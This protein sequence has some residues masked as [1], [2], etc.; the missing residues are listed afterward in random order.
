MLKENIQHS[1]A[2]PPLRSAG[3]VQG[4]ETFNPKT[5]VQIGSAPAPGAVFR[6]PAENIV[7]SE[8][9][10]I[11]QVFRT[12]RAGYEGVSSNARGGRAPQLRFSG[13]TLNIQHP[14]SKERKNRGPAFARKLRRGRPAFARKFPP[15]FPSSLNYDA[16]SHFGAASRRGR[17]GRGGNMRHPMG[18]LPGFVG[19]VL[20]LR[21][22]LPGAT[23]GTARGT[24]S[25]PGIGCTCL[26]I[27]A[28]FEQGLKG[29]S[30]SC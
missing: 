6:A 22:K 28:E 10:Q 18:A 16:T 27:A 23:P 20:P 8:K 5:E 7:R 24:R 17:R 30:L 25:L 19:M 21:E 13:S 12:Q 29:H 1:K 26:L 4:A 2:R 3:A 11:F 9:F 14:T 15:S